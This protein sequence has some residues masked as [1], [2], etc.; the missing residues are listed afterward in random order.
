MGELL[1]ASWAEV[2]LDSARA[3]QA[4]EKAPPQAVGSAEQV[5]APA[6]SDGGGLG[7]RAAVEH[8]FG[9]TTLVG[10]DG[11][12]RLRLSPRV[13]LE[14]A[15]TLRV[16]PPEPAPHRHVSALGSGGGLALLFR[17]AAGRRAT[18]AAGAGA[19]V[20]WLE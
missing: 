7:A 16:G 1:R 19:A 2:A 20:G 3:R 8:Y 17:V 9:G 4:Q 12:G 6:R 10:A 15:G 13:E 18:L 11:V 5:M 14:I